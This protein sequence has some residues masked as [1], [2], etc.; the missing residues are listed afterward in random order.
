MIVTVY[1]TE[2]K[3]PDYDVIDLRTNKRIDACVFTNDETGDVIVYDLDEDGSVVHKWNHKEQSYD[4]RLVKIEI[5]DEKY[6]SMI[7]I[8]KK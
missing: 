6:K 4:I 1:D 7:K 8:V 3:A 2:N 5:V